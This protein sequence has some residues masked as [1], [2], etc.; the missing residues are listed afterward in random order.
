[1]VTFSKRYRFGR[2]RFLA[3]TTYGRGRVSYCVD[4]ILARGHATEDRVVLG[5]P[6]AKIVEYDEE[7]D[8]RSCSARHLPWPVMPFS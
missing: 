8:C 7:L 3:T 6:A 4:D 2:H 5:E 1:M